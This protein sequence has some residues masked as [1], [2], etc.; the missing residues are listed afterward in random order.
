MPPKQRPS[1]SAD[2]LTK[3]GP[4]ARRQ[5]QNREAQKR[6]REKRNRLYKVNLMR[7]VFKCVYYEDI[8]QH[9]VELQE[10]NM[11]LTGMVHQS[12][13]F[14]ASTR[15]A[16]EHVHPVH[17]QTIPPA[18]ELQIPHHPADSQRL[19]DFVSDDIA[20][21]ELLAKSDGTKAL[22]G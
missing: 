9:L 1:P 10:E 8:N 14:E 6:Y 22:A 21:D 17:H 5:K 18:A 11:S 19:Q 2:P 4:S 3:T 16:V 12:E 7:K 15:A 20:W 13:L